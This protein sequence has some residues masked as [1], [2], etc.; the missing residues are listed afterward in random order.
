[1]IKIDKHLLKILFYVAIFCVHISVCFIHVSIYIALF[2]IR[3]PVSNIHSISNIN[4]SCY[5]KNVIEI[6]KNL[7]E[8]RK[9]GN[10]I[11]YSELSLE[12]LNR[13]KLLKEYL[14]SSQPEA[15]INFSPELCALSGV[16][17]RWEKFMSSGFRQPS[18]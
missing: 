12:R 13:Q 9:W 4:Q 6:V 10:G 2:F 11:W 15:Y 18:I 14:S 16:H 3:P 5:C 1:M 8:W 17:V 7:G